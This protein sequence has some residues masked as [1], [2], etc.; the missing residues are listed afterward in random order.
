MEQLISEVRQVSERL[1]HLMA[2][3]AHSQEALNWIGVTH[4]LE[5][6]VNHPRDISFVVSLARAAPAIE[7]IFYLH[8]LVLNTMAESNS[9]LRGLL[10]EATQWDDPVFPQTRSQ[11]LSGVRRVSESI[12]HLTAEVARG[13]EALHWT[14]LLPLVQETKSNPRD[15][16][17]VSRLARAA[18][19]LRGFF[20]LHQTVLDRAAESNDIL[21]RLLSEAS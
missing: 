1:D 2:E 5:E 13:Q 10:R 4:L 17:L 15:I 7:R 12:D 18:P 11:L 14:H 9:T 6:V 8:Q 19:D 3:I 20:Q 21:H 16:A